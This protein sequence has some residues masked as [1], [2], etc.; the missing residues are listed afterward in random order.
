VPSPTLSLSDRENLA[1]D[2]LDVLVQDINSSIGQPNST[3]SLWYFDR[4]YNYFKDL[5]IRQS[6]TFLATLAEYDYLTGGTTYKSTVITV[7]EKF[8]SVNP[9]FVL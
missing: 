2:A 4:S 3:P 8:S 9:T 5:D 7:F 6:A 1:K